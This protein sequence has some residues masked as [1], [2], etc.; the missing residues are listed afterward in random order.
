MHVTSHPLITILRI[1]LLLLFLHLIDPLNKAEVLFFQILEAFL[2]VLDAIVTVCLSFFEFEV[3]LFAFLGSEL[4][5]Q[6]VSWPILLEHQF[7]TA[8]VWTSES[9]IV[10]HN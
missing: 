2:H 6:L 3:T 5:D 4:A 8:V 7:F 1:G 9:S 10:A